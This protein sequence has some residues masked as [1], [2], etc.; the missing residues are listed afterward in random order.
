MLKRICTRKLIITSLTL[1]LLLIIYLIPT[2]GNDGD[3]LTN[4]SVHYS[5]DAKLQEV[6]LLDDTSYV[7]RTNIPIGDIKDIEEK[8]RYLIE[9]LTIDGKKDSIIPNGFT[10]IIPNG[11]EILGL[12]YED[13]IVKVNFSDTILTINKELEEKMV[14]AITYTLTSIEEVK[15]VIIY[16]NGEI[17]TRLPQSKTTLPSLL[18]RDFG[19]NKTYDIHSSND[20]TSVVIYYLNKHNDDYY[21]VPVTSYTNDKREKIQIIID[22]LAAGPTYESNLMSFVNSN[23]RLLSYEEL[24]KELKL[25]FNTYILS[26]VDSKDI[27]EEVVYSIALSIRDNYDV[28]SVSIYVDDEEIVKSVIKDIEN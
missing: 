3:T 8:C 10:P 18:N 5:T 14:E 13:G 12:T 27:L 21:Y 23:V 16:V 19:I 2:P 17:L 11:T 22:E 6:F 7:A 26:D 28:E 9:V 15:G 24:D 1:V 25:V 4:K 20:I